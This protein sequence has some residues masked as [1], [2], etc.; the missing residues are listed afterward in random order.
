MRPPVSL[1]LVAKDLN[2]VLQEQIR[3]KQAL[4]A[5]EDAWIAISERLA[6]AEQDA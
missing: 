5:T 4:A 3:L 2:G 6:V 1:L